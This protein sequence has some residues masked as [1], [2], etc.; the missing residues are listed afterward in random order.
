[1]IL[2]KLSGVL[3]ISKTIDKTYILVIRFDN[4]L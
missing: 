1:M 2:R 3:G 4:V